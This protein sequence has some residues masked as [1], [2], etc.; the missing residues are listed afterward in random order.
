MKYSARAGLGSVALALAACSGDLPSAASSDAGNKPDVVKDV[1]TADQAPPLSCAE[2][3]A[4]EPGDNQPL[5]SCIV[6]L[7]A[8]L[9]NPLGAP[10][11]GE[12]VYLC[13]L[14]VCSSELTANAQGK[15][16]AD[17]CVW[18]IS[19]AIK[20]LGGPNFAGFA[21]A[22]PPTLSAISLPAVTLVPL[23]SAGVDFPP[24]G[25][26]VVSNGVTMTVGPNAVKFDL[27]DS[28]DGNRRKFRAVEVPID[29]APPFLDPSLKLEALWGMS[30]INASIT[31]AALL[32]IPNTKGW[33]PNTVVEFFV[34]GANNG[35]ANPPAPYGG[36]A[37][38][39]NGF[40]SA[41]GKTVS[42]DPKPGNGVAMTGMVGVRIK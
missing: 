11:P 25:G 6:S 36:W 3:K 13:G 41:D 31:P 4:C 16:H 1:V 18:F 21:M 33:K 27:A 23:P 22:I 26:D 14:T 15:V 29:K 42:M 34:N 19:A 10:L 38:I 2:A 32:T 20:Y 12:A 9:V 5:A 28:Q 7:D 39:G 24:A 30:P 17:I 8:T 37:A 35:I 40:V